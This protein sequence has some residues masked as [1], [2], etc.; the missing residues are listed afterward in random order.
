MDHKDRCLFA[1]HEAGHCVVGWRL[2]HIIE[3]VTIDFDADSRYGGRFSHR[4]SEE[5][6]ELDSIAELQR[7]QITISVGGMAGVRLSPYTNATT[8]GTYGGDSDM[9]NALETARDMGMNEQESVAF[10]SECF[11]EARGIVLANQKAVRALADALLRQNTLKSEHVHRILD[12]SK[13]R[14]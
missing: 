10:C 1:Y 3:E 2:G 13:G 4:P 11:D 7:K 8:K 5:S 6:A 9:V 12:R 14:G